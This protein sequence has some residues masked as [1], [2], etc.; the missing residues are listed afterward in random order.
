M[1]ARQLLADPNRRRGYS[2]PEGIVGLTINAIMLVIA[3]YVETW[4]RR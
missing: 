3:Y 4:L 1:V 2:L